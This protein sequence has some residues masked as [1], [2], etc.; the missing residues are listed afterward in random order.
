MK[1]GIAVIGAGRFGRMHLC[2]A[3]QLERYG[4]GSLRC[5]VVGRP[6]HAE[7]LQRE[8]EIPVFTDYQK[9]LEYPGVHAVTVATPDHLHRDITLDALRRGLHVLVE[10]PLDT[11][12]E[13]CEQ[14]CALADRTGLLVQVDFHKRYDPDHRKIADRV[15][16][17]DLGEVLYGYV[18]MEDRIEVPTEWFPQWAGQSSPAWFLGIHFYDLVRW[19]IGQEAVLVEAHGSKRV[20]QREYGLDTYDSVSAT[21]R[22][23]AGAVVVFQT[24]WILPNCFEAVV[25]QGL[26]LV[27]SRGLI[28]C[29][30]QDR[31]MRSCVTGEGMSTYNNN[32][33]HEVVGRDGSVE[34]RGYGV[35][36]IADFIH[37]VALVLDGLPPSELKGCLATA[38]DGLEA[39]RIAHAVHESLRTGLPVA[40]RRE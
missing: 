37:N 40:V 22:F 12:P 5:A 18:H 4:A 32:F 31:G 39:T 23:H 28:E 20:L 10:K 13:G 8:Y 27:G 9:V 1:P 34:Y 2:V 7:A 33:R 29:D 24:S 36:S 21:V 38:Q 19:M 11:D 25:N 3:R 35:E 14:I 6:E 26:R 17:G 15:K 30:S 16:Q